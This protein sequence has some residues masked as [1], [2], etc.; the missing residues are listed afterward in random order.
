[1]KMDA[2]ISFTVDEATIGWGSG[3]INKD[4]EELFAEVVFR[5]RYWAITSHPLYDKIVCDL[6]FFIEPEG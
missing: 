4:E 6:A 1:M 5:P 2:I 3:I